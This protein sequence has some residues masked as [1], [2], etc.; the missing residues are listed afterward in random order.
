VV[1]DLAPALTTPVIVA[2]SL[3]EDHLA[4]WANLP[5][6]RAVR[7]RRVY[8]LGDKTVVHP[9]QLVTHTTRRIAELLH[10]EAFGK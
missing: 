2:W 10:P 1:L 7:E 4:I 5:Q 6:V 3:G 8:A 9:S